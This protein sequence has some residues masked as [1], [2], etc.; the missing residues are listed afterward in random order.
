MAVKR[1][2]EVVFVAF[3]VCVLAVTLTL[4]LVPTISWAA[5]LEWLTTTPPYGG[6]CD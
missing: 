1:L 5:V 3:V 6:P 2:A 4:F